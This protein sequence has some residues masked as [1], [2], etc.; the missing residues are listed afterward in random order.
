[1]KRSGWASI[2]KWS[3]GWIQVV[4]ALLYRIPT[5]RC[6]IITTTPSYIA[7]AE[8]VE[9]LSQIIL[10]GHPHSFILRAN[11]PNA[12]EFA[13]QDAVESKESE[14]KQ[15]RV[16]VNQQMRIII[17]WGLWSE[18]PNIQWADIEK[19]HLSCSM[20][21]QEA[22]TMEPINGWETYL[23]QHKATY[24]SQ[25]CPKIKYVGFGSGE[26]PITGNEAYGILLHC[27]Y[28]IKGIQVS[29]EARIGME[30]EIFTTGRKFALKYFFG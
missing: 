29:D 15:Q 5:L 2:P 28:L 12:L 16:I 21:S 8:V 9:H 11:H 4:I 14:D 22:D 18:S 20:K 13:I 26:F 1:M 10:F 24:N 6:I 17:V 25:N 30:S 3:I 19:K 7:F 27:R 23:T